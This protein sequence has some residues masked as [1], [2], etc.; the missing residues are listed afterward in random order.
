MTAAKSVGFILQ[1]AAGTDGAAGLSDC[2]VLQT[3]RDRGAYRGEDTL[4]EQSVNELNLFKLALGEMLG[5][6]VVDS[7]DVVAVPQRR[8]RT[9]SSFFSAAPAVV[10]TGGV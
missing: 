2:D 1:F 8:T 7:S 5:H 6:E 9:R 10:T 3:R 4:S